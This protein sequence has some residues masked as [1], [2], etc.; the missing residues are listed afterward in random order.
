[1]TA[2]AGF[3]EGDEFRWLSRVAYR[4]RELQ[5]AYPER[6]FAKNERQIWEEDP[7]WQGVRE[8]AEKALASYDWGESFVALNLITKPA[9]DESLRQLGHTARRFG[10]TLL[11]MLVDNQMR[12][13]DR[14]RR[15][16]AALVEFTSGNESNVSAL[17]GWVDS[18]MPLARKGPSR[19][20]ARPCPKAMAPQKRPLLRS[21]NIIADSVWPIESRAWGWTAW[22]GP[23]HGQRRCPI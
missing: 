6:G 12:D 16:S 4:T 5:M 17:R 3:Q 13:W 8:L 14:S 23:Y 10:D 1:M 21:S 20:I 15:W 22:G 19:T 2:C 11:A 9:A 18:W 7:A